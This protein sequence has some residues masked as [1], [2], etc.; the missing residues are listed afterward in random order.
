MSRD[1]VPPLPPDE[2]F[3]DLSEFR[4]RSLLQLA[5]SSPRTPVEDLLVF[6]CTPESA[7][8]FAALERRGFAL[9]FPDSGTALLRGE[10]SL[11]EISAI[12]DRA[13]EI[14][15][16]V[17]EVEERRGAILTYFLAIAAALAGRG[18]FISARKGDE[19]G[20]ILAELAEEVPAPWSDL[21]RRAAAL[22]S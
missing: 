1:R 21:F 11:E 2:E 5:F 8:W 12:K 3:S 15:D 13:K 18:A 6:L 20:P 14:A 9:R 10:L 17:E 7:G 19:L 22:A 16:R 4:S